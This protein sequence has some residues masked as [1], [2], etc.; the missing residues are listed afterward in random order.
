RRVPARSPVAARRRGGRAAA[1]S[2]PGGSTRGWAVWSS[3][4]PLLACAGLNP[5]NDQRAMFRRG[6]ADTPRA[7]QFGHGGLES[8]RGVGVEG[9][10]RRRSG[11]GV[12]G[13]AGGN[14]AAPAAAGSPGGGGRPTP[15]P[16]PPRSRGRERPAPTRH[17]V[18]PTAIA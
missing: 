16:T 17:T 7:V 13:A 10:Q 2:G 18:S 8:L 1:P 4:F 6:V 5:I 11:D 12:A 3:V 15:A 14:S 9:E